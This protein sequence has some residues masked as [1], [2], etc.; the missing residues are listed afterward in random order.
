MDAVRSAIETDAR[1]ALKLDVVAGPSSNVTYTTKD[2]TTEA[3]RAGGRGRGERW[4]FV[5]ACSLE[6]ARV[7]HGWRAGSLFSSACHLNLWHAVR[8]GTLCLDVQVTVGRM[9]GNTIELNDNEISGQHLTLQWNS[10]GRCWQVSIHPSIHTD[11]LIFFALHAF[12]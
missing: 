3:S 2:E 5:F 6:R 9:P 1:L 7:L 4:V 11:S 8:P 10:G 12:N